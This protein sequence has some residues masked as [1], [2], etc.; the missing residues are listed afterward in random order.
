MAGFL[1]LV[2]IIPL[3]VWLVWRALAV[4]CEVGQAVNRLQPAGLVNGV[5]DKMSSSMFQDLATLLANSMWYPQTR[6]SHR[7]K[8]IRSQRE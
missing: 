2:F 6:D 1:P 3:V 5:G 8:L 4:L 7:P